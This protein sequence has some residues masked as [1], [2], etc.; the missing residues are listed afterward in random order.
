MSTCLPTNPVAPLRIVRLNEILYLKLVE[1]VAGHGSGSVEDED[2]ASGHGV[3][4]VR[5]W[6]EEV[7]EESIHQL[8]LPSR[9]LSGHVVQDC[10]LA[11]D[12]E[13]GVLFGINAT[14]F[15]GLI[16][17]API[18]FRYG[19]TMTAKFTRLPS[20]WRVADVNC[21]RSLIVFAAF[22]DGVA[23]SSSQFEFLVRQLSD[24]PRKFGHVQTAN[25]SL[26]RD[27][28]VDAHVFE[29]LESEKI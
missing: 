19:P 14:Q 21:G 13:M 7:N 8:H 2:D 5:G 10:Q 16:I 9:R 18:S 12:G 24:L 20:L 28:N 22:D 3:D 15:R 26:F 1:L 23:V 6:G 27:E 25:C 11:W 17:I 4:E 29:A